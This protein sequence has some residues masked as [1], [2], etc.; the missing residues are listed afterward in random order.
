MRLV[1]LDQIPKELE[2]VPLDEPIRLYKTCKEMEMICEI[3]KG[4]GLSAVQVGIPWRLF[5]M[6]F[7]ETSTLGTPGKY[8]Y[9]VNC[10]YEGITTENTTEDRIVSLEGCLSIRSPDGQLRLFQVERFKEIKLE[11]FIIEEPSLELKNVSCNILDENQGVV[12]Q[13]EIDHQIDR[14]IS[15]IGTEVDVW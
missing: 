9:F 15:E 12:I 1:S 10:E 4:I 5:V 8:G 3:E 11:G 2:D 14:L 13:H 7:D 6:K